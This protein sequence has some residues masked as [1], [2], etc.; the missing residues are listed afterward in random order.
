MKLIWLPTF[1]CNLRCSYCVARSLPMKHSTELKPQ[2]W[3]DFFNNSPVEIESVAI[4]GGEPT[5]YPG[6]KEVLDNTSFK[7]TVD[8]N[9]RIPPSTFINDGNI[10][11][12]IS[13]NLSLHFNP[14]HYCAQWFW[15]ALDW[16]ETTFPGV[17]KVQTTVVSTQRELESEI[18]QYKDRAS[19][20]NCNNCAVVSVFDDS[21]MFKSKGIPRKPD[22]WSPNC[23]SGTD[24]LTILADGTIYRCL[25][26]AYHEVN[27]M[28]NLMY[29]GWDVRFSNIRPCYD[30]VCTACDLGNKSI[31]KVSE[32][33]QIIGP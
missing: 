6:F 14:D 24:Y 15:G 31:Y 22:R 32:G 29:K 23:D 7:F 21:F 10:D 13:L 5:V 20:Y 18:A 11:R 26:H 33:D 25:G 30:V 2:V 12:L 8:T 28:G 19:A 9:C 27:P 3:I 1:R 4:S 16:F 17:K